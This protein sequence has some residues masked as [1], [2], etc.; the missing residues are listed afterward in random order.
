MTEKIRQ[1]WQNF[2]TYNAP[3]G[4]IKEDYL[5]YVCY[6]ITL[7]LILVILD[8]NLYVTL[9]CIIVQ[10]TLVMFQLVIGL[11]WWQERKREWKK[12]EHN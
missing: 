5:K 3:S 9:I 12:R 8:I 11:L 2:L 10:L 4:N 1:L 7:C 6:P